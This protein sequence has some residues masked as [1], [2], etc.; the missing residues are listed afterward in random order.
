LL[1][2]DLPD[3]VALQ[4]D[5]IT[6]FPTPLREPYKIE[7]IKH[8][9][10]REIVATQATNSVINR[11]GGTF[12]NQLM[13]ST[14]M[15]A[16]DVVRAYIITRRC[17]G[18]RAM[19]AEIDSLDNK[20]PAAV[21]TQMRLDTNQLTEWVTLWFLR[22][23]RRPL[24]I[25]S[26]VDEFAEGFN[27]LYGCLGKCLPKHYLQDIVNRA[28]PYVAAGVPK[29]LAARVSGL[30]NMF[31]GCDIIRLASTRKILVADASRLYFA[32]GSRFHLGSLRAASDRLEVQSHWQKLA[33]AALIEEI[34]GHQLAL[35]SQ[36]IDAGGK[37]KKSFDTDRAISA[38]IEKNQISVERMDKLIVELSATE[39][40]DFAMISVASRQLKTLAEASVA[41]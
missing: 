32:I 23:G 14:G 41:G 26:H 27:A 4:D 19:W 35:A 12:I 24:D 17:L 38:W 9:L 33:V 1:A 6:Y 3:D 40:N 21:Q 30:V 5:L 16:S 39:I 22:N 31:S 10:N 15:S 13:E 36:V 34:Y 11:A 20:V 2:S 28:E 29:D 8:R 18:M 37:R 25:A 7:I